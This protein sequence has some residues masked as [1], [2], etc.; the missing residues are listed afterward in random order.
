M[1]KLYRTA[2][3]K[4]VDYEE[5][6]LQNKHKRAVGNI[7]MNAN[8]DEIGPDGEIIRSINTITSQQHFPESANPKAVKRKPSIREDDIPE[9]KSVKKRTKK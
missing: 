3:G 6:L 5:L 2:A 4:L 8:G 7:P 9:T 1:S